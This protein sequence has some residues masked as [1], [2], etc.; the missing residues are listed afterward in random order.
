MRCLILKGNNLEKTNHPRKDLET[1]QPCSSQS[2]LK[3]FTV[4]AQYLRVEGWPS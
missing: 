3:D 2:S 4:G 1:E